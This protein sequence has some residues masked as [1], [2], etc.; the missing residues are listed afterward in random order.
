VILHWNGTGWQQVASPS[1]TVDNGLFRVAATSASNAWAVGFTGAGTLIVAWNGKKW[2]Q[3][4]SPLGNQLNDIAAASASN[5]WTVGAISTG[6]ERLPI[7][8]H[9]C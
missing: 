5:A 3:V 4:T 6:G 7:A 8:F 1:P 2:A 9:C